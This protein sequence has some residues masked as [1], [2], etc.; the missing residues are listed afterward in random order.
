MLGNKVGRSL[1]RT[2]DT[3]R[4]DD[5][6]VEEEDQRIA[7]SGEPCCHVALSNVGDHEASREDSHG[8]GLARQDPSAWS[9]IG[10]ES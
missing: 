2:L 6:T 9:V 8:A 7:R 10:P 5:G 4:R 3:A 1:I